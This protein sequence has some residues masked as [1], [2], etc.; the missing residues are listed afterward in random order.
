M[1][2]HLAAR[3]AEKY[4]LYSKIWGSISNGK[5]ETRYWGTACNLSHTLTQVGVVYTFFSLCLC[6]DNLFNQKLDYILCT[7]CSLFFFFHS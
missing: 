7:L 4:T 2:P 3:E 6:R 5:G 1:W